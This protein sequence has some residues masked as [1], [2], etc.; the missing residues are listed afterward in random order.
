MPWRMKAPYICEEPRAP[1]M[2]SSMQNGAEH[3]CRVR[4]EH[5]QGG[6]VRETK[7][8]VEATS[9]GVGKSRNKFSDSQAI[10]TLKDRPASPFA[11]SSSSPSMMPSCQRRVANDREKLDSFNSHP[12]LLHYLS[13]RPSSGLNRPPRRRA[14]T[15]R[16]GEE[17]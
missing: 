16:R 2:V 14:P 8:I 6:L 13:D 10:M 17:G 9:R 5:I 3:H 11:L 7:Q 1:P 12:L 4:L 15:R